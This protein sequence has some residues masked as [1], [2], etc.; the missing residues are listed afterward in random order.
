[1]A[2]LSI[3]PVADRAQAEAQWVTFRKDRVAIYRESA[4][5]EFRKPVRDALWAVLPWTSVLDVGCNCGAF[6]PSILAANP[7][8]QV[9]GIDIG[10]DAIAAAK[11]DWPAHTWALTSAL[12]WLPMMALAGRRYDVLMSGSA[13][14]CITPRDIEPALNAVAALATRAIVIQEV[15][16]TPRLREGVSDC[17]TP[18]WRYDYE[19]RLARRH[20]KL[21]SRV[22]QQVDSN[23][24]AAVMVFCPER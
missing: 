12:D 6:M 13:L 2:D 5:A 21:A 22:W 23:R 15:T 14:S 8:A 11:H 19:A 16:T 9:T 18:E 4:T 1:M 20:W 10:A 3:L 17:G 24:P 7:Q